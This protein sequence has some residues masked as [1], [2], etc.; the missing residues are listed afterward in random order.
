MATL[1]KIRSKSVLLLIVIGCAL[2]AFIIGDFFK[3]TS[4]FG[5]D[6][7]A[8]KVEGTKVDIDVRDWQA[9]ETQESERNR[10]ST[11][12]QRS[13]LDQLVLR[14]MVYNQLQK[15]L[16]DQLGLQVSD[17]ELNDC[18]NGQAQ[19]IGNMLVA[20]MGISQMM[21]GQIQT[22]AQYYDFTQH[23]EKY[24]VPAEY[25]E[26]L[27]AGWFAFEDQLSEVLLQQKFQNMLVGTLQPNKLDGQQLY[28]DY[29]TAYNVTMASKPF[30]SLPDAQFAIT[31]EE[32]A[33]EWEAHK[34]LYKL[35]EPRRRVTV[36]N[37]PVV[38]SVED[39]AAAAALIS[40]TATA[41][42]ETQDLEALKGQKGFNTQRARVT[43]AMVAEGVNQGAN[44]RLK[45][46]I[47]SVKVGEA[48]IL[49]QGGNFGYQ[50]AKMFAIEQSTDSIVMNLAVYDPQTITADS[51]LAILN[52]DMPVD[53]I[54]KNY[55][56][57]VLDSLPMSLIQPNLGQMAR[58]PFAEAVAAD[59]TNFS[60]E[61]ADAPLGQYFKA[62]TTA[63]AQDS[64][65]LYSVKSRKAP[66]TA[67]DMA[68]INYTLDPS[69]ET[70]EALRN[71]LQKFINANP[72]AD[73]LF[74][75]AAAEGYEPMLNYVT[76]SSP[77]LF[78]TTSTGEQIPNPA[79]SPYMQT[80]ASQY[81]E[82]DN[83]KPLVAWALEAKQNDVSH[84][85]GSPSQGNFAVIGL[86]AVYEGFTPAE[87]PV[88]KAALVAKLRNDKKAEKMTAE[89]KGKASTV[90]A[91]AQMMEV[92][93]DTAAVN[94]GE[95][96]RLG[97]KVLA[98]IATAPKATVSAP[99]QGLSN[100][101]VFQVNDVQAP[102][103]QF[104]LKTDGRGF[105]EMRGAG[106][107]YPLAQGMYRQP[108]SDA[109]LRLMLGKHQLV[110][111][112]YKV[113]TRSEENK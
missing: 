99:V 46:A 32:V 28:D 113:T 45:E 48:I 39:Q 20:S 54:Q 100:L 26:Q 61:F 86:N 96:V 103:R 42:C 14:K 25:A 51:M 88:V 91:Y 10:T 94:F 8:A 29:N 66:V 52:S 36:I 33:K 107:F 98:A 80:G 57:T 109:L 43:S 62:D 3:L 34:N 71:K 6:T 105:T 97:G 67:Y 77:Y 47:D 76:P 13:Y 106:I 85:F 111:N 79:Y 73:K 12:N 72:T 69:K 49:S 75:N 63:N 68:I 5:Q 41:L 53:S 65:V 21:D 95:D 81:L 22:A 82:V 15:N 11:D 93:A 30:S 37:V 16:F 60:G 38:P 108:N 55:K 4:I 58:M 27:R 90:E 50:I 19:S 9:E 112:L 70:V 84:I 56:V 102:Q 78:M 1:E 87:D 59:L 74:A 64:G 2:L 89:Y 101:V 40:Q 83:S 18:V 92:H 35:S 31:D 17:A 24:Q 44:P 7:T 104:N 23:P 110:N